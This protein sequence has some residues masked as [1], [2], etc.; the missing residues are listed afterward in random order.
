MR[1]TTKFCPNVRAK[2]VEDL[3]M[4][5]EEGEC[6]ILKALK[7]Y[8]LADKAMRPCLPV[9]YA[10]QCASATLEIPKVEKTQKPSGKGAAKT[11]NTSKKG[12]KVNDKKSGNGFM[13]T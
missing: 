11:A 1:V 13:P 5:F 3:C 8:L 4:V 6:L 9:R 2:C 7:K 10:Q 12:S